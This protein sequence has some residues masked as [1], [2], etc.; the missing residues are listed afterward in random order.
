[1]GLRKRVAGALLWLRRKS[2]R[3][4]FRA[5]RKLEEK[6][7]RLV[8]EDERALITPKDPHKAASLEEFERGR[9]IHADAASAESDVKHFRKTIGSHP[10]IGK[11]L[12][13]VFYGKKRR[14]Q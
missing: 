10:K 12:T 11:V 2:Q 14:R 3:L 4:E 5:L 13:R 7:D 9:K 6:A 8:S 1:M